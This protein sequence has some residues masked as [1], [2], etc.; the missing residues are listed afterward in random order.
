F[1]NINYDIEAFVDSSNEFSNRSI[2]NIP[3]Y[4]SSELNFYLNK[5]K[6]KYLFIYEKSSDI[7]DKNKVIQ[8]CFKNEILIK[9]II[10]D[11][12]NYRI[13]RD[14]E[15]GSLFFREDNFNPINLDISNKVILVTGGAGSIGSEL[16][17]QI[18]K[19]NPKKILILDINELGLFNIENKFKSMFSNYKDLNI[20]YLLQ[21]LNDTNVIKRIINDYNVSYLFHTA[22]Y[23][24]VPILEDNIISAFK[25]N[26]LN[27]YNL[28]SLCNENKVEKFI[29]ISSD[30]AVRP[31]NIMGVTKRL[32]ELTIDYFHIQNIKKI[33][34]TRFTKVRFGNVL[35]SSGSAIPLFKKQI[36][37]DGIV[38][39]THPEITRY[40]MSIEEA[41]YLV[42]QSSSIAKGGETF[43]LDMGKPIKIFDLV[44]KMIEVAGLT[45]KSD[46]N[47]SGDVEIKFIG[48]RPGEKLYEELLLEDN[49]SQTEFENIYK[50]NELFL[51]IKDYE[52]IFLTI[53]NYIESNNIISLKEFIKHVNIGY[54]TD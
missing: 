50:S 49:D 3:I 10:S 48:L 11:N 8:E 45:I 40:F 44:K 38:T 21:N 7:F 37:E 26:F 22:A 25:N 31:T 17:K 34:A 2:F 19:L 30:K 54:N 51:D 1:M 20:E 5:T 35:E 39:V 43:L 18:L 9:E 46:N 33:D 32:Q 42:I 28:A 47:L 6:I 14:I 16:C 13:K 53:T 15:I 29:L 12:N 52:K 41:V 4:K 36:L 24:H 27:T 23:K